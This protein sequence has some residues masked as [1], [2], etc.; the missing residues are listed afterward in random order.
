MKKQILAMMLALGPHGPASAGLAEGLAA[1]H[2][3]QDARALKEIAPLA[4]AGD[5]DAQHLLG[6]MYY[7]GRGVARDHA[8]AFR[9]H[10]QAA[11]QGKAADEYVVGAMYY[12][13]DAVPRDEARAVAWF[14]KAAEQGHT[15]AQYALGLLVRYHVAG[16]PEDLV[17]AYMLWD[18]AAAGGHRNAGEQLADLARRMTDRQRAQAQ[19]LSRSWQPG[20]PLP[21]Q[22]HTTTP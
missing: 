3:H 8:Q 15:D 17:L 1:Y 7:T 11:L 5:A 13:G 14:R 9:W 12:T 22:L 2:A 6:L 18:R 21:I 16:L 4:R 19:Q 10:R 20:M